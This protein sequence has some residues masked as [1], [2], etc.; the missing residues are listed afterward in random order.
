MNQTV[1][2]TSAFTFEGKKTI[3]VFQTRHPSRIIKC[4]YG[5]LVP[6]F[7]SMLLFQQNGSQHAENW[8]KIE[9]MKMNISVLSLLYIDLYVL[10]TFSGITIN[11]G[12]LR[13]V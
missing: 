4:V 2:V 9:F 8:P 11:P 3:D 13:K 5:Q 6:T 1:G 7:G 12:P 10:P